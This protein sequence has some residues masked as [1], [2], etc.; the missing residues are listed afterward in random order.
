MKI[1]RIGGSALLINQNDQNRTV[2]KDN[3]CP[4]CKGLKFKKR[5][6]FICHLELAHWDL[7]TIEKYDMKGQS[8][9]INLKQKVTPMNAFIRQEEANF[10][11]TVENGEDR[12]KSICNRI[13]SK[14]SKKDEIKKEV[15]YYH[16]YDVF[17]EV[18]TSS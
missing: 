7:V 1:N 5:L 13:F 6:E 2:N 12:M 11:Y 4:F 10:Y 3:P 14:F 8:I 15:T 17:K 9:V 16:S 18:G